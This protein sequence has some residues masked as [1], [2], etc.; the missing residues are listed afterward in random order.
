VEQQF[1]CLDMLPIR[2]FPD[3]QLDCA[4]GILLEISPSGGVIHADQ[5]MTKGQKFSISVNGGTVEAEI[6]SSEQD[7]FGFYLTFK[8]SKPWFPDSYQP[9]Y[10]AEKTNG[11]VETIPKAERRG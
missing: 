2:T 11:V 3:K 10:L 6:E 4:C 7:D 8:V 9:P 1:Y 5:P